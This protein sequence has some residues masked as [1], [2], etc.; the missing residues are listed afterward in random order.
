MPISKVFGGDNPADRITTSVGIDLA[1]KHM[2]SM[3][4]R[5]AEGRSEAAV[6]LHSIEVKEECQCERE[7]NNINTAKVHS[8]SRRESCVSTGDDD[9]PRHNLDLEAVRTTFGVTESA[10]HFEF[11]DNWRRPGRVHRRL[12]EGWTGRKVFLIKASARNRLK[13]NALPTKESAPRAAK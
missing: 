7:S 6:K 13:V 5:L 10:K 12:D 4:I 11:E 2:A 9:Y 1:M 3:G 8:N